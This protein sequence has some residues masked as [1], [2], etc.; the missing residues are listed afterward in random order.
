[1]M[2]SKQIKVSTSRNLAKYIGAQGFHATQQFYD[3]MGFA[4]MPMY[5]DGPL[6]QFD[7]D[8]EKIRSELKEEYCK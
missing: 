8:K 4:D 6:T 1:M 5:E 2:L 3:S 7:V